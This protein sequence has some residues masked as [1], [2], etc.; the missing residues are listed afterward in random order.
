MEREKREQAV[1]LDTV[2]L[3]FGGVG[4]FFAG[5]KLLTDNLKRLAGRRLRRAITHW[6]RRPALAFGWGAL[7]GSLSQSVPVVVFI[8]VG[9]LNAGMM[10]V[11]A[12]LPIIA[13][14]NVGASLLVFL[15]T[16][17]VTLIMM[18][19]I[20]VA[21]IAFNSDRTSPW[22]PLVGA[23]LGLGLL[24]LGIST[25][26]AGAVPLVQQPWASE[27]LASARKYYLIVFLVAAA[28]T[29]VAQ[30]ATTIGILAIAFAGAGVFTLE[31]TLVAIYG[32][33]LGSS[34]NTALLTSG[35][36]GRPRQIAQLQVIFNIAGC[37]VLMPLFYVEIYGGVPLVL[38]FLAELPGK[39]EQHMAYAFLLFNVV[40]A[41]FILVLA[42][43]IERVGARMFPPSRAEDDSRLHYIGEHALQ[44]PET[45]MD[46]VTLEQLR[47]LNFCRHYLDRV[48]ERGKK[49][50]HPLS[51]M[52]AS[53]GT[54]ASEVDDFLSEL[55][56]SDLDPDLYTSLNARLKDQKL[57]VNFEDTLGELAQTL[58]SDMKDSSLCK[59][60]TNVVEALDTMLL[61]LHGALVEQN[62]FDK[63]RLAKM[64]GDRSESLQ[65]IRKAYLATETALAPQ[66]KL[67][68]L[69]ITNLCE[70]F[71]SLVG[72]FNSVSTSPAGA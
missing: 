46:L 53:F 1:L 41:L 23:L 28:L 11:K 47:L 7:I 63:V 67:T 19:A 52:R 22:Q 38:S 8:L 58:M 54:L 5:V 51:T 45:A 44:D 39:T 17:D 62:A 32:A 3:I 26:Q 40:S 2:A 20:G 9:M 10:T 6:T 24:F 65:R 57:L 33:N 31:Q 43:P 61:T 42:T 15:T 21:G 27:I 71:F 36:R 4:L 14:A 16:L 60:R 64:S 12:A 72:E 35:L 34:V 56:R 68:I 49:S 69:R 66:D 48:R 50:Q 29:I 13:G 18:F 59:F 30:A 25:L 55:G 37:I 70:K